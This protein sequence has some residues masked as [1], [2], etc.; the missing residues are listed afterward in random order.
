MKFIRGCVYIA[1][2]VITL[3]VIINGVTTGRSYREVHAN[4]IYR[5]EG[6]FED[7]PFSPYMRQ[8]HF[9]YLR[10]TNRHHFNEV[11]FL[12]DG[13]LLL[14]NLEPHYF[15]YERADG[16][17]ALGDY[18]RRSDTPFLYVR[19]PSKLQDNS[20][21]PLAFSNNRSIEYGDALTNLISEAG[22]DTFDIREEMLRENID[23]YTAFFDWITTGQQ[24][25]HYGQQ[26]LSVHI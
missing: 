16:I 3:F 14:D 24:K 17:I 6:L 9:E 19:I 23:F 13:R 25:P 7:L 11:T 8:A 26:K 18:L 22:I 5:V 15:L 10:L 20:V 4:L 21:L 12:T 1:M 2:I